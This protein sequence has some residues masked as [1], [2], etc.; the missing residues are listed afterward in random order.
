MEYAIQIVTGLEATHEKGIVHRDLK[1]ANIMVS[2]KDQIKAMDFGL[3][4]LP[5]ASFVTGEA[6]TMGTVA[7]RSPEQARGRRV[8]H[9]SDL[10]SLGV[11]LYELLAGELPFRDDQNRSLGSSHA[12]L[13]I[14]RSRRA[15][16]RF[17][18]GWIA[19]PEPCCANH[20]FAGGNYN[21]GGD[22]FRFGNL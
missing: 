6:S 7:C 21:F 22:R 2:T 13:V 9:R 20:R 14:W 1:S 8:D 5:L 12:D 10:W 19:F 18:C 16:G 4:K 11:V 3:A 15:P 17:G